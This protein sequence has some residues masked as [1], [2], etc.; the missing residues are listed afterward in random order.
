MPNTKYYWKVK[1]YNNLG[2]GAYSNTNQ[3]VT[4]LT[5]LENTIIQPFEYSLNQNYPNPFNPSTSIK[6]AISS[7]QFVTLKVYDVIGNEV[8]ILVSEEK[9]ASNYEV[10]FDASK[11]SSGVYY[12]QLRSGEFIQTKKMIY[13]K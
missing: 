10:S 3:F 9:P 13:L 2:Y 4:T 8:A 5:D 6:Y 12:Y 7:K 1:A 11:L